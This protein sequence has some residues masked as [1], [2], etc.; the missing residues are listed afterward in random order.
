MSFPNVHDSSVYTASG[1]GMSYPQ[2]QEFMRPALG[3]SLDD[4]DPLH[5]EEGSSGTTPA[6]TNNGRPLLQFES[7]QLPVSSPS[8]N[9][10]GNVK[11][12]DYHSDHEHE[13]EEGE[14]DHSVGFWNGMLSAGTT[15][16]AASGGGSWH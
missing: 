14:A 12:N 2:F 8:T 4:G 7:L 6:T 11:E 10:G 15:S 3:F 16:A 9:S 5:Q 1:F 13:K